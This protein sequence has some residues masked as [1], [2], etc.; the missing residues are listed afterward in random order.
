MT[1]RPLFV[2][3]LVGTQEQMGTQHGRL[4]AADAQKLFR[5]Y[6][7]MPERM[8][9][10]GGGAASKFVVRQV[11]TAWQARLAR[12]RPPELA[13]R[14]AAFVEAASAGYSARDRRAARLAIATMDTMQ[15]CVSLAARLQVG[16]FGEKLAKRAATAAV[17]ACTTVIAWGRATEDGELLFARN[18]DFPGVGVW[19]T[20]PSFVTCVPDG[21]QR[22]G[23]F[24]TRGGDVPVVSVVNEA[25]LVI[26]PHTRWHRD[27]TWGG[28]M[29]VDVV[30]EIARKAES[31]DDAIRIA[32]E[33]PASSSWGIAIGS[34]RERAALV[35]E[36]AG[37][38]VEIVRPRPGAEFIACTNRYRH[39]VI[40][41]GEVCGS[42]AWGHH[43]NHREQRMRTLVE[44]RGPVTPRDLASFLADREFA[45][46]R[47]HL[48]SILTQPTNVHAVV[49]APAKRTAWAGVDRAP[50]TEGT[51]AEVAWEWQGPQGGWELGQHEG[52]GF[53]LRELPDWVGGHDAATEHV[54]E[55]VRVFEHDHD[56][57]ASRAAI[58]KA[59][60]A[61]P[62][63][64]SLRLSAAWLALEDRAFD[65]AI[66]HVHAG[67]ALETEG[68]RRGQLLSCGVRAA[69]T[70]DPALAGRWTDELARLDCDGAEEL[71][72][73]A[74]RRAPIHTNLVMTD[75]Y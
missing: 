41:R 56:I 21:G 1:R 37:P 33:R 5:F 72:S 13:A 75:A 53:T 6:Q 60:G 68:Y 49:I 10:G 18:F 20:A 34:A 63:D 66:V 70:A 61:D 32:K 15:N 30:H 44:S 54:R 45:G 65:R 69:R 40:Q 43:S 58:E 35:L 9:A 55:A 8:L 64:P 51:W 28:A 36:L 52:S 48:G 39:E 16:P 14:T 42:H 3:R 46:K 2:A 25:G 50:C 62:D 11:A 71:R 26:S 24:A 67:L 74:R 4:A 12:E 31:L 7:T 38:H 22:Y 27:V 59:I 23:F 19:D 17:P 47:R 73:R 29:I 57:P